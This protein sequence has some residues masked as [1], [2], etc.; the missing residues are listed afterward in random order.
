MKLSEMYEQIKNGEMIFAGACCDCSS[1][2]SIKSYIDGDHLVV[3][4]GSMFRPPAAWN[5]QE[6]YLYKCQHCFDKDPK[7]Y[8]ATEVY[9]RVVGYM[10]PISQWNDGKKSEYNVRK[11]FDISGCCN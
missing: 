4:G 10:R 3:E 1:D 11:Q 5:H 2:V 6:E 9:S 8:P 7:Y